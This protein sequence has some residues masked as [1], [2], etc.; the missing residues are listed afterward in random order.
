MRTHD[1]LPAVRNLKAASLGM[2]DPARRR[3]TGYTHGRKETFGRTSVL[4]QL[5]TREPPQPTVLYARTSLPPV[6]TPT[7]AQ[8]D[9]CNNPTGYLPKATHPNL[10]PGCDLRK[11]LGQLNMHKR[12]AAT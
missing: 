3:Y 7:D 1:L 12:I 10:W 5:E 11:P 2:L 9:P 4:A 6:V 8:R